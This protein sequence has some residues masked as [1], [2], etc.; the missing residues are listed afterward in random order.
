MA[1]RQSAKASSE[2]TAWTGHAWPQGAGI[3]IP[4]PS[5]PRSADRTKSGADH[6]S[7]SLSCV[8]WLI[9]A[10]NLVAEVVEFVNPGKDPLTSGIRIV[11]LIPNFVPQETSF[12]KK[13][14]YKAESLA[15]RAFTGSTHILPPFQVY[16]TGLM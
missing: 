15:P 10:Q 8:R 14:K 7:F 9:L 1:G 2:H 5:G 6:F 3:R 16:V 13:A 4:S 11:R 12:L